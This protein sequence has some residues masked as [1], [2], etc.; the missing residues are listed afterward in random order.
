MKKYQTLR[1]AVPFLLSCSL[2]GVLV[3]AVGSLPCTAAAASPA[4]VTVD[5]SN[6]GKPISGDLFGIF[7]EDLNYAADGG[8]YAELVQNRSFEYQATEQRNWNPLS[9]WDVATYGDGRGS[10]NV[11]AGRPVHPN[12]THYAVLDVARVGEGVGIKNEGFDGIAVREGETYDVSLFARQL[13]VE[14][15]WG[16]PPVKDDAKFSLTVRLEDKAGDVLGETTLDYA[17]PEWHKLTGEITANR[18]V[19]DARLVVLSKTQGGVALDVVSLFPRKTFRGRKNGLRADLAATL[20]DLK[21]A[22][23]RFPGGCLVHGNGLSNMY[24]W[25]D[26]VG[27]VEARREQSNLWGYHQTGGLGYF[28]YFRF[29]EDIGAKP[30]PVVPSGMCCQNSGH[31]AGAGQDGLPL[32]EMPA[33]IQEVLD[34][35]EWA[36]GPATSKW[37]AVRA[38][39][40]HPEPFKLEYLGIGNEEKI[41][42]VFEER[43][44]M[45]YDSVKKKHPEIT[46]IGTVGPFP[47]GEDYDA[48]WRIADRLQLPIVDEH[49]YQPPQW[50]VENAKRYDSYDRGKSEV[51]VGEYA[52]H[53]EG[54]RTTLRSALAEAAYMTHLERNGDVVRLASYAPLLAKRG[55]T[56]WNPDLIYFDNT[57]VRPTINYY[58]Q[59]LFGANG[60][61]RYLPTTVEA[62]GAR[63]K[64]EDLFVSTVRDTETN[65]V[66]LKVVNVGDEPRPLKISLGEG[67]AIQGEATCDVLVG[68][69]DDVNEFDDATPL[70][71]QRSTIQV[72]ESFEY[73]APASSLTVIRMKTR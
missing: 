69:P 44:R 33:Y 66:I 5:V 67:A 61:D 70:V 25:Q 60:G 46:V 7:F 19:D 53:D 72:G 32:D 24:R 51:Y 40:G 41:T 57:K 14:R 64:S 13:Y 35:V 22:F 2:Q 37:G 68:A 38:A 18:T 16:G 47:V 43:F 36:T 26:T 65:D 62:E 27:P 54:R 30:L 8:L 10:L 58:V 20:A 34:L 42:P 15:R 29:C 52:A 17:G 49:Y 39:A 6:D 63:P 28:E 45:I 11:D 48:G 12:N 56:Q 73:E 55:R 4:T 71:P 3:L 1:I 31:T 59:Q 21:P 9:F 23:V 50:F